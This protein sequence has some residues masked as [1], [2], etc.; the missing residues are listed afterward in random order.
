MADKVMIVA[1]FWGIDS[2]PGYYRV[3]RFVRW[4]SKSGIKIALLKAG[5]KDRVVE[6]SWGT[7]ITIRDPLGLYP[8]VPKNRNSS[9]SLHK[10]NR[11]R[12]LAAY[13]L[14]NP[15]PSIFWAKRAA[16]HS[17]VSEHKDGVTW[18]LSSS[19]PESAHIAALVLSKRWDKNLV[20]DMRDG[21]LD[22]PLK[23]LLR[24]LRLQ[25]WR[26]GRLER[27][28][29]QQASR[30]F[31]TSDVWKRLLNQ[32]LPFT[33]GKTVVLTNGFTYEGLRQVAKGKNS[34]FHER[35]ILLHSGRFTGSSS[36]RKVSCLLEP[37][38]HGLRELNLSVVI[39]LLGNLDQADIIEVDNWSPRLEATN[40]SIEVCAPVPRTEA[41]NQLYKSDGLLL[42][43]MSDAAIPSKLFEYLSTGLPILAV[44]LKN[45]AVW[46]ICESLPQ[47]FLVDYS[48]FRNNT[49]IIENFLRACLFGCNPAEIPEQYSEAHLSK[50]FLEEIAG[51]QRI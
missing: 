9:V 25:R 2:H 8:E 5:N 17:F 16:R 3:E 6:T 24:K 28:V 21:W 19:P 44:T 34:S 11:F 49:L 40:C 41:L 20:V 36:S 4:L 29:L 22:E 18:I 13:L 7:E 26:E 23:P 35:I 51:L 31:V 46:R 42:L 1:P 47:V 33:Q 27:R 10:P 32:R 39:R 12:A 38:Y 45:S 43:S 14:C 48:K 50:I 30:I 37:L 15:D